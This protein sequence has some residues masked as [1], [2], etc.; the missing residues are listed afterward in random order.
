MRT[1]VI[2]IS[3]REPDLVREPYYHLREFKESA[4]RNGIT[5]HFLSEGTYRGLLSKPKFLKR[6]LDREGSN[7]DCV[8]VVDAWDIIFATGTDHIVERFGAFNAPIL[9]NAER[10]CF[11][12]A[13]FAEKFPESPTPYRYLNSGFFI[14]YTDAVMAML[15]NM[16][17][18]DLAE[19]HR[20]PD[21]TMHEPNDQ[22]HYQAWY[23]ANQSKAA[24]DTHASV[25]Q[26]LHASEPDEFEQLSLAGGGIAFRSRVTGSFPH[27][28]HGNG[29]GKEWL[30]TIIIAFKL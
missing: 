4:R 17:L 3:S 24:L 14:G 19:D 10:S 18:D 8:I 29:S 25:C 27:V 13:D 16:K 1:Q 11:P 30:K 23:L 5:P 22:E 20:R 28:F 21:G 2:T 12:R 9:F 26:S 7:F 6:Y 15:V